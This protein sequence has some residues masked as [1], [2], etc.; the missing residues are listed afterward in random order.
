MKLNTPTLAI[1]TDLI[2][3]LPAPIRHYLYPLDTAA[4]LCAALLGFT[5][6][7]QPNAPTLAIASSL[8]ARWTAPILHYLVPLDTAAQL[9]AESLGFTKY[10]QPNLRGLFRAPKRKCVYAVVRTKL[11]RCHAGESLYATIV[12]AGAA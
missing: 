12:S 3:R 1:A 2:T 4:Q 6:C 9:Y 10:V 7:V 5:K 8:V 11:S